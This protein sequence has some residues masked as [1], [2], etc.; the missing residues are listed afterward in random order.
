MTE[1][2]T[3]IDSVIRKIEA[4]LNTKGCTEAEALA[5][6]E[7]AQELLEK[8]NLDMAQIGKRDGTT[9]HQRKDTRK[10]G[11]LYR[12]QRDLWSMVAKLNF[13]HHVAIKG[14]YRGA[15]YEHRIV[16]SHA[17]VIA[18]EVMAQYLQD[19]I[20]RLAQEWSRDQG[21]S[22]V[23]VRD[24]IAFREGCCERVVY[25]L[26]VRRDEQVHQSKK[27]KAEE[28]AR[29]KHPGYSG[30]GTALTILDVMGSESDLNNDYLN[31]WEPGTT[32]RM[33]RESELRSQKYRAQIEEAARLQTEQDEAN[34]RANGW[35]LGTTAR[36]RAEDYAEEARRIREENRKREERNSKKRKGDGYRYRNKTEKEQ[37]ADLPAYRDGYRKGDDIGLDQQINK[38]ERAKL[39]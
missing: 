28:E 21:F 29:A 33:R 17:N 23:F 25:R 38:D 3:E 39:R 8:Y 26:A 20:E 19:T 35:P 4:L 30:S 18:T 6:T 16:G 10:S 27:T 24:A 32:A 31:G 34:D 11:G 22:S 36:K 1:Q 7:K 9:N 14:M 12:W 15:K 37:R 2:P 5:R 13:C